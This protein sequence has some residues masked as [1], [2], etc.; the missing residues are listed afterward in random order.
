MRIV[1]LSGNDLQG[2]T[3]NDS[4]YSALLVIFIT[5]GKYLHFQMNAPASTECQG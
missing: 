1:L 5:V 3:H 4:S 2:S